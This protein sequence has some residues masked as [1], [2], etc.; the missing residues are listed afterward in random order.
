MRRAGIREYTEAVRCRYLWSSK[1][2]T[3]KILDEFTAALSG[4]GAN[5]L[6]KLRTLCYN[7]DDWEAFWRKQ[8]S[9]GVGISP[10]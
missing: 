2:D 5:N 10:N 7:Q 8:S 1:T 6:L 4:K 3:G 9:R